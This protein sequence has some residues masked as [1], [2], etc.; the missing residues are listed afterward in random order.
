MTSETH[1]FDGVVN[2][3]S[4]EVRDVKVRRRGKER[5]KKVS[6]LKPCGIRPPWRAHD[7]RKSLRSGIAAARPTESTCRPFLLGGLEIDEE[8]PLERDY[9]LWPLLAN[10]VSF[11]LRTGAS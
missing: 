5:L 9:G 8:C 4:E 10:D 1:S 7:S 6:V 3:E 2:R 11:P